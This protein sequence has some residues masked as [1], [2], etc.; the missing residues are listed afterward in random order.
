MMKE[1]YILNMYGNKELVYMDSEVYGNVVVR[2]RG[3][4]IYY[5]SIESVYMYNVEV[6]IYVDILFFD[7]RLFGLN[8][9]F[10]FE[11]VINIY[12]MNDEIFIFELLDIVFGLIEDFMYYE[13]LIDKLNV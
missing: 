11:S 3:F 4:S 8:R 2:F 13:I 10:I 5:M 6:F 12:Y 7:V 9:Y 1:V